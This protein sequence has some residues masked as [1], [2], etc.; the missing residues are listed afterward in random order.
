MF[1]VGDLVVYGIHGVC[2]ITDLEK[3]TVDRRQLEY[4]V[5]Q[6]ADGTDSRYL[7]PTH[8]ETALKKLQPVLSRQALEEILHSDQIRENVWI[9]DENQRRQRYRELIVGSDRVALLQMVHCL[10]VHKQQIAVAG[11]K[12]HL[13]DET[14]LR[15]AE[16]LLSSEFALVLGIEQ[17]QVAGYVLSAMEEN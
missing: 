13:C 4:L 8:N 9:E 15:D 14:F 7:V 2:K 3:R 1:S 17:Q 10:H 12:F 11:R 6:P 16:R 5:L